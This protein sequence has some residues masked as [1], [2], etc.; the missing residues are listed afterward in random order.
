MP[1][2]NAMIDAFLKEVN[3]RYGIPERWFLN[4]CNQMWNYLQDPKQGQQL[5]LHWLCLFFSVLACTPQPGESFVLTAK[6]PNTH[7]RS[8]YFVCAST[9][10]RLAEDSYLDQPIGSLDPST[11]FS[12]P[13]DGCILAFLAIPLL[14]DFLAERGRLS[15]AWKLV[16]SGIRSAQAAGLHRD[17]GSQ[18]WQ[19]MSEGE[20]DLRRRAWWGLYIWDRYVIIRLSAG[21]GAHDSRSR[22]YSFVLGRPQMVRGDISDV[23]RPANVDGKGRKNSFNLSRIVMVQLADLA[24]EI[25]DKV[26]SIHATVSLPFTTLLTI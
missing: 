1:S 18:V 19:E 9:A 14:C 10:R 17:P 3:W 22:L 6:P 16:G 20:K 2:G 26:S 25:L 23:A 11:G 7:D 24:S 12:S 13:T 15:E 8:T 5:N 21:I 4:T